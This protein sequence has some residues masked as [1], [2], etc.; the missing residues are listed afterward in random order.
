MAA[1]KHNFPITQADAIGRLDPVT[2]EDTAE[3][4]D[5]RVRSADLLDSILLVSEL[6]HN[7]EATLVRQAVINALGHLPEPPT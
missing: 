3:A 7:S 2:V 4:R 5:E 1:K 6:D